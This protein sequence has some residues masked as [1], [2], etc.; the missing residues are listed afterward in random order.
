MLYTV[1]DVSEKT[2]LT[3]YTI[4]YYLKEGLLPNIERDS[5]GTRLFKESDLESFYMI[6][7]LK[8]CGMTIHE[9]H[10]YMEWLMKGDQNIGK[11][12]SLFQEKKAVLENELKRLKEVIEA[13][14]YKIWYYETANNAG[15]LLVHETMSQEEIPEDMKSIRARM[16]N[17]KRITE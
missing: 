9:I 11:C 8:R 5:N 7:C 4:R 15:T 6:E 2:G 12:L 14:D 16:V 17:V 10:Q 13:V 1:K 3:P